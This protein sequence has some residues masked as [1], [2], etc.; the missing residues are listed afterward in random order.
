M[1]NADDYFTVLDVLP[2]E[3]ML[4]PLDQT[5]CKLGSYT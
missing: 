2:G 1:K 5:G 3:D 4:P